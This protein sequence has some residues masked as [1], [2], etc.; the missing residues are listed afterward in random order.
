MSDSVPTPPPAV[1]LFDG[2]CNLCNG[3]VQFIIRYDRAGRFRFAALQSAAGQ[4]LLAAHGL[5]PS[6]PATTPIR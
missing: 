4:A 2:V 5:P 1:V 3:L 6:P